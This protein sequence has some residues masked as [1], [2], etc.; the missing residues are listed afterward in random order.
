MEGISRLLRI[1][2]PS[3]KKTANSESAALRGEIAL[4]LG[5]PF[6]QVAGLTRGFRNDVMRRMLNFAKE[7]K[8]PAALFWY[9]YKKQKE[10]YGKNTK[11]NDGRPKER[12]STGGNVQRKLKG[13]DA[14]KEKGALHESCG[15]LWDSGGRIQA[16]SQKKL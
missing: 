14:P 5:K 10:L 9:L 6:K 4:L 15:R 13:S 1:P 8:N 3:V 16:G 7:G 11:S 12:K 2:K